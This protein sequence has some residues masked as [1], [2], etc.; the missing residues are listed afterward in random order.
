MKKKLSPQERVIVEII[1]DN[2]KDNKVRRVTANT[3]KMARP[4]LYKI[5]KKEYLKESK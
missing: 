3:W 2:L 4:D 1:K 5:A